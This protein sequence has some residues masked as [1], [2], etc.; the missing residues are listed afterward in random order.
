MLLAGADREYQ[1][2]IL[3]ENRLDLHRYQ[4]LDPAR[5][6]LA[7]G[8]DRRVRRRFHGHIVRKV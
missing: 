5:V 1:P 7:N 4:L 6:V 3:G 8:Y 2:R